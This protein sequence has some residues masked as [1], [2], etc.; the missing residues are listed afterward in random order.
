MRVLAVLPLVMAAVLPC[1]G[2]EMPSEWVFGTRADT[3]RL[4][5]AFT[6]V[7]DEAET[8]SLR[9]LSSCDCLK[10]TPAAVTLKPG[11]GAKV[12]LTLE[13][14]GLYGAVSKPIMVM[15]EVPGGADRLLYVK[16]TVTSR[17]PPPPAAGDGECEWCKKLSEEFKKQAYESWRRREGVAHYYYSPDCKAC[18]EFLATE[19]PRVQK[20]LGIL[21]EVDRQDIRA[22]EALS[23]LDAELAARGLV[24]EAFPVLIWGESVLMGEREIRRGFEPAARKAAGS[25]R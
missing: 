20:A 14:K 1:F 13:L 8:V 22:P 10:V 2:L 5:S 11:E 6:I 7:N 3:E 23:E 15:R 9:V 18:T 19:I 21:I 4:S 25:K 24:V 12:G 17:N 16:G